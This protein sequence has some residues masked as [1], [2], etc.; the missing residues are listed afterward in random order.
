MFNN[1]SFICSLS[2][3]DVLQRRR[4][5]TKS[6]F[7][8]LIKKRRKEGKPF[9][10]NFLKELQNCMMQGQEQ[11]VYRNEAMRSVLLS[12]I[13]QNVDIWASLH[14]VKIRV[15]VRCYMLIN[16]TGKPVVSSWQNMV[17]CKVGQPHEHFVSQVAVVAVSFLLPTISFW[18]LTIT[19][20]NSVPCPTSLFAYKISTILCLFTSETL[21][22]QKVSLSR[23]R[24]LIILLHVS[25][26]LG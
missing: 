6:I 17:T 26:R 10:G 9:V 20:C 1:Q 15:F 22:R 18:S 24:A 3:T 21:T 13:F 16:A 4:K 12:R 7:H 25:Q 2:Q 14:L 23:S 8:G 19:L 5:S 11:I